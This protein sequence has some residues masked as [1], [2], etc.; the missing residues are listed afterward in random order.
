MGLHYW[1]DKSNVLLEKKL[2]I[3][4]QLH[5]DLKY[6]IFLKIWKLCLNKITL[7]FRVIFFHLRRDFE[8]SISRISKQNLSWIFQIFRDVTVVVN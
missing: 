4:K 8:K 3:Q 2:I 6:Q 1:K 5:Q 7:S